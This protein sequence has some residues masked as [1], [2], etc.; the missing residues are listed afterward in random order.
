MSVF[1]LCGHTKIESTV[2]YLG[3]D[4]RF[5]SHCAGPKSLPISWGTAAA[6]GG[7]GHW[8]RQAVGRGRAVRAFGA[9]AFARMSSAGGNA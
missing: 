8:A 7:V 5:C 9:S 6:D 1:D 2:R 4:P 3:I